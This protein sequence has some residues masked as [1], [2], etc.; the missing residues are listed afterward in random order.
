MTSTKR[1]DVMW[2]AWVDVATNHGAP[3]IDGASIE[4]V[5][6]GGVESLRAFLDELAAQL[7]AGTYPPNPLRPV[8]VPMPSWPRSSA[9]WLTGAC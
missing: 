6:G 5:A 4:S 2:M 8:Y 9:A 7:R 1:S 3:G